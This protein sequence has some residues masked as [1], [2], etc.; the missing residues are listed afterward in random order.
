MTSLAIFNRRELACV[1]FYLSFHFS[2]CVLLAFYLRSLV[3]TCVHLCSLVFTCVPLVYHLCSLVFICVLLVFT[4]V[5]LVFICLH[6]CSLVF[7]CVLFVF[8]CVLLVFYLCSTCVHLCSL[9]F[10]LV[11]CFRPDR[12]S[13]LC[14]NSRLSSHQLLKWELT[15]RKPHL[16]NHYGSYTCKRNILPLCRPGYLLS[17]VRF[18]ACQFYPLKI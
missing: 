6:L 9:V 13:E 18:L 8:T 16:R 12:F 5:L 14:E 10:L 2:T 11:W 4:C 3:F 7:I 1:A 15:A 17:Q